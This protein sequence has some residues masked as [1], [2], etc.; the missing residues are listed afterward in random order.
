MKKTLLFMLLLASTKLSPLYAVQMGSPQED[1]EALKRGRNTKNVCYISC[2]FGKDENGK[3]IHP[4]GQGNAALIAPDL[5]VTAAHVLY[6]PLERL[7]NDENSKIQV[8]DLAN[9]L[10]MGNPMS[11]SG[12]V[13]FEPNVHQTLIDYGNSQDENDLSRTFCEI[14]S[15]I[16]HPSYN[17][18]EE[19]VGT[20]LAFVKLKRPVEG[21]TPLA[22]YEEGVINP[23]GIQKGNDIVEASLLFKAHVSTYGPDDTDR[24]GKKRTVS[25][26]C[27]LDTVIDNPDNSAI[28][29]EGNSNN[30]S[31]IVWGYTP[32]MQQESQVGMSEK[33]S[34]LRNAIDSKKLDGEIYGFPYPGDS[35]SPLIVSD[36]YDQEFIIGVI[37][38]TEVP[39]GDIQ[40]LNELSTAT[41]LRFCPL[42]T[43]ERKLR[44]E[45]QTMIDKLKELPSSPDSNLKQ[46]LQKE[47]ASFDAEENRILLLEKTRSAIDDMFDLLS[48]GSDKLESH[49]KYFEEIENKYKEKNEYQGK[50]VTTINLS[51]VK[52]SLNITIDLSEAKTFLRNNNIPLFKEEI[53]KKIEAIK[54]FREQLF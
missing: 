9:G 20:D 28:S 24:L 38:D 45:I 25:Q 52:T 42:F 39:Q 14:D 48:I 22:L 35:G 11:L 7:M 46:V 41:N 32:S 44:P 1:D 5:L 53:N 47:K 8:E 43:L 17:Y 26:I 40:G 50:S 18:N 31:L 4:L 16:I 37:S 51:E 21:I 34:N 12:L 3:P 49:F 10:K 2:F 29:K 6:D 54:E 23:F 13:T 36:R 19:S 30:N 33:Q 15:I 27:R